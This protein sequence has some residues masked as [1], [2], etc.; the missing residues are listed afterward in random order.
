[1]S[2]ELRERLLSEM[3]S[4][5]TVD[6]HS[7]TGLQSGYNERGGLDL[8]S[9]MAY[10][11]R[12]IGMATGMGSAQLY[13][14]CAT[15][16]ERWEKLKPVLHRTRNESYWRHNIVTYGAL[17]DF[18]DDDLEDGNW[19]ALNETIKRR[20]RD[21]A[22]YGK[23]TNDIA[24]IETQ[25]LNVPWFLDWEPEFFTCTLRMEEA[26]EL[27]NADN[28]KRLEEHLDV[29]ITDLYR[30]KAA[31]VKLIEEYKARG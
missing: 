26:L 17:F 7:H 21:P 27:H 18:A 2:S 14:G 4:L 15:D 24:K 20:T 16:A 3:E 10:Y 6:C 22:W 5:H 29:S 12:E 30:L 23:V 9:M 1:M 31:L 25:I 19:S 11:E 8:F 13:D 28:R